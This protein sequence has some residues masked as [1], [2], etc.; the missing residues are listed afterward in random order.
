MSQRS[1][2]RREISTQAIDEI[3]Q[4]SFDIYMNIKKERLRVNEANYARIRSSR[5]FET[6]V[7]QF[8]PVNPT[9]S[10]EFET[11]LKLSSSGRSI[12]ELELVADEVKERYAEE[13]LAK[14]KASKLQ[15][16]REKYKYLEHFSASDDES[17]R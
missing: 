3:A 2:I 9:D 15:E 1:K 7:G 5:L 12:P 6:E 16:L 14:K 13:L 17:T 10:G 8:T 4:T 11:L